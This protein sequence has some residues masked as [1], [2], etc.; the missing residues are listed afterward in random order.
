MT[1]LTLHGMQCGTIDI[2][3][4]FLLEG[5]EGRILAPV[6]SY[7]IRHPKGDVIFDAG[8]GTSWN[9]CCAGWRKHGAERA[10]DL[11]LFGHDPAQWALLNDDGAARQI[12][13]ADISRA[14]D[15]MA[16]GR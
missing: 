11:L 6:I 16:G 7:L 15:V 3:A 14:R 1:A 12:T 9:P 10:G 13:T 8:L 5:A 2:P 4:G